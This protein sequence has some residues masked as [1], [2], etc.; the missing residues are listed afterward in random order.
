L[1]GISSVAMRDMAMSDMAVRDMAVV[2]ITGVDSTEVVVAHLM[3]HA[4]SVVHVCKDF[5][6]MINIVIIENVVVDI[7]VDVMEM[8]NIVDNFLMMVNDSVEIVMVV[9]G[10]MGRV[11]GVSMATRKTVG[12]MADN[13]RVDLPRTVCNMA[14]IAT[15]KANTMKSLP[16][17]KAV[18]GRSMTSEGVT[19]NNPESVHQVAIVDKPT[20]SDMTSTVA[21][22]SDHNITP[23]EDDAIAEDSVA[24]V[25]ALA[26]WVAIEQRITVNN[27]TIVDVSTMSTA[28]PFIGC[29]I[30]NNVMTIINKV[31]WNDESVTMTMTLD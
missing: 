13:I 26:D 9:D 20:V 5:V 2:N 14:I 30:D 21:M 22:A 8:L 7:F 12:T 6:P 4:R 24:I 28:A 27:A 19:I 25:D 23:I 15:S 16:F 18:K 11:E 29:S 10:L 31:S 3:G 1:N 17:M